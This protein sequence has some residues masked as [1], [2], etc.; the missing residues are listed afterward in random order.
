[1]DQKIVIALDQ[2]ISC[3]KCESHFALREGITRQTIEHYESELQRTLADSRKEIEARAERRAE[4]RVGDRYES[5]IKRLAAQLA[6]QNKAVQIART[7]VDKARTDERKKA[8]EE[9]NMEKGALAQELAQKDAKLK[10]FRQMELSLRAE[11]NRLEEQQQTLELDLQRRLDAERDKLQEAIAAA[12]AEKSHFREAELRKQIAD[13]KRTNEELSRKLEQKSQQLQGEVLELE[14]E[15]ALIA[16]FPHDQVEPVKKGCRGADVVQFVRTPIGESCGRI[17]WETKRAENWSAKW[18]HKLKDD[19]QEIGAEIPVLITTVMPKGVEE[20]FAQ[21]EGVWVIRPQVLIPVAEMLRV[22]LVETHRLKVVNTGRA[23]KM[24]LLYRYL[25]S[26]QFAQKVRMVLE[27]FELMRTDL[28]AE[29]KAIQRVWAKRQVQIE[30]VT[31][32]LVAVCGELQAIADGSLS[33][34]DVEPFMALAAEVRALPNETQG[35]TISQCTI[36][37]TSTNS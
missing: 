35:R 3:P 37:G 11:K 36:R 32:S 34:L 33:E 26:P 8:L 20:P 30:K 5:E 24:E 31:G 1:M 22:I 17:V 18:L 29:K 19:Q 10:E 14:V 21:I 9:F 4:A 6:E 16:A 25:S 27:T 15:R 7:A 2:T 12:E 28:E 13:A 23:E